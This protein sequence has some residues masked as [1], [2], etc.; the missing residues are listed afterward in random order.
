MHKVYLLLGSNLGNSLEHINTAV[1]EISI[2]IGK[3]TKKSSLYK[4][5]PWGFDAENYFLNQVIEIETNLAPELLL[6][7]ILEIENN[8]GRKRTAGNY[9]SRTIDIDILFYD[10]LIIKTSNLS[11]PHPLIPIRRFTL[12]PLNEIASFYMHPETQLSIKETLNQCK[13]ISEVIKHNTE[14]KINGKISQNK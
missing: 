7:S 13:D 10:N 8:L 6:H 12:I 2:H 5:E 1:E 4:S 3:V 14:T 11:I 9:E